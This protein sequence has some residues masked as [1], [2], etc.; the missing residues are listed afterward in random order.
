M[1]LRHERFGM[2]AERGD[3]CTRPPGAARYSSPEDGGAIL[4]HT[5]LRDS[6][7]TERQ[8]SESTDQAVSA[9]ITALI[10]KKSRSPNSPNSRPLP[11]IL[12]PPKGV[13][14]S[15]DAPLSTT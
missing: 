11:D 8:L 15:P 6:P 9:P 2:E 4:S 13:S 14:M 7:A 5:N 1:A 12:K 10:S 3:D